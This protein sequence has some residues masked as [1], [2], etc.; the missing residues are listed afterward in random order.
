MYFDIKLVDGRYF[1]FIELWNDDFIHSVDYL[2]ESNQ[3]FDIITDKLKG[4]AK[5]MY[6]SLVERI[7][8]Q[9]VEYVCKSYKYRGDDYEE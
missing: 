4:E 1:S 5:G 9:D 3:K 7:S 2:Y 8:I 6:N